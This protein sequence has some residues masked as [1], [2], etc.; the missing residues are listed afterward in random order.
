M[1]R[2]MRKASSNW[3]GKSIMAAVLGVLIISFGVWGIA[4]IFKGFGRATL[5]KV[6]HTEIST[7]Q[8]RQLFTEKL[9][10]IGRQ[11]GRPL[12]GEQARAFGLDRQLLQ[13]TV[14]EAALDEA[15][16]RMG[17]A[18]S[19]ADVIRSIQQD[20]NFRGP[21]GTFDP[22]PFNQLIRQFGYSEP[23]YIAEQRRVTLRREIVGSLNGDL[24]PAAV[25]LDALN[26]FQNEQ[27]SVEFVRL[28]AALAGPVEAP[29]PE[30]LATYF[31]E[32]KSLFRAPEYRKVAF[33]VVTPEDLAKTT[34]VSDE[35]VKKAYDE[36]LATLSTP[37][38]RQVL[39]IGFANLDDAKA[40]RE[41]IAAGTSFEDLAKERKLS[42]ADIDLGVVVK[43]AILD[44]VLADTAFALG[45]NDVS[46]PV[47]GQFGVSIVKVTKIEPGTTP[48]YAEA[49]P[50]LKSELAQAKARTAI[51]DVYNKIEDERGGGATIADAAQKLGLTPVTIDAV[52]RS[53]RGP[54]GQPVSGLPQ[55]FDLITA[56]FASNVNVENDPQQYKGGF[57]WFDVVD[58]VPSRERSLEEVKDQVETRW[59]DDQISMRLRDKAKELQSK[60]EGGASLADTAGSL[61]VKVESASAFKRGANLDNAPQYLVTAAFRTPKDG[62]GTTPGA[63]GTEFL[64]FRVTDVTVPP[65]DPA[66]ADAKKLEE[67]LQ[68]ALSDEQ[69]NQFIAKQEADI[70]VTINEAAFATATGAVT[71]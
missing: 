25:Q 47:Q 32:R 43:S 2:G 65:L 33:V 30:A 45:L 14:S 4:D 10:Q 61:G 39:Q 64:V 71:N 55:G 22:A 6:G 63:N 59:K 69:L 11:F 1:L 68:R 20:P 70:G 46:Q 48:S 26:R 60:L 31:D 67:N 21:S 19:D 42:A 66:S 37:E 58:V 12:T 23:R 18:Q 51:S 16:R 29:A 62:Y 8:F 35:D 36:R 15:A 41:K 7:E 40:A 57:V 17:L 9:Q 56:A 38:K 54:N 50:K 52:D 34:Q 49:A 5:A 3:L 44:P 13:Q 28:G 27:R 53:G 24:K